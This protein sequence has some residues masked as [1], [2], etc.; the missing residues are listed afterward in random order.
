MK[1]EGIKS[2][3]KMASSNEVFSSSSANATKSKYTAS[4]LIIILINAVILVINIFYITIFLFIFVYQEYYSP[5]NLN[6][7]KKVYLPS[8]G[9]LLTKTMYLLPFYDPVKFSAFLP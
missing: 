9:F 7:S 1:L 8:A 2:D 5:I 3:I 4:A 6:I